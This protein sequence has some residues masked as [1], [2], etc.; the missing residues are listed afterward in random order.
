MKALVTARLSE[1]ILSPLRPA[2]DLVVNPND[3]PMSRAKS[4]TRSRQRWI[5][6]HDFGPN[7]R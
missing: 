2:Y 3:F 1:E 4:W 6:L 5:T 7:R